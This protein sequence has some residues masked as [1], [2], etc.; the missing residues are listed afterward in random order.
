MSKIS[1]FG[2]VATLTF[3]AAL[4]GC[5]GGGGSGN[6]NA[7]VGTWSYATGQ[8]NIN[9]PA[10][11]GVSSLPLSGYSVALSRAVSGADLAYVSNVD[12]CLY[13][14]DVRG[15]TATLAPS[16]PCADSGYTAEYGNYNVLVT[17]RSWLLT[18][19]GNS[20]TE[21]ASSDLSYATDSGDFTCSGSITGASLTRV[22]L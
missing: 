11:G 7:F 17:P 22:A 3:A 1:S 16:S 21:G 4:A 13:Y 5:G 14:L 9:C 12:S 2:A 15:N 20:M 8:S 19:S 18:V 10:T 6:L